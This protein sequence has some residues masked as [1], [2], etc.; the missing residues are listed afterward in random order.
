MKYILLLP[1]LF[2]L[3]CK[4]KVEDYKVNPQET[5]IAQQSIVKDTVLISYDAYRVNIYSLDNK[6]NYSI[7]VQ[8]DGLLLYVLFCL[9]VSAVITLIVSIKQ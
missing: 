1:L 4:D 7:R 3:S 2:L 6:I 8:Q 5:T 9:L